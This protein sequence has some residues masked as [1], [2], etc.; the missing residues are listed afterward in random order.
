MKNIPQ[1]SPRLGK[2]AELVPRCKTVADIGTDHAY[3]PVY[4]VTNGVAERAVAS[5]IRKGPVARARES[6]ARYELSDKIDVR[7]GAGLETIGAGEAEVVVV[8]GMGGILIS[9]ILDKSRDRIVD[10]KLLILQ[11]M[12]AEAELREYLC[13]NGYGICGE[14]LVCEEDKL[15]NIITAV[16]RG[17]SEYTEVEIYMGRGLE[18]N[19]PELAAE[20]RRRRIEKLKK[21]IAGLERAVNKDTEELAILRRLLEKIEGE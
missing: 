20:Y 19:A 14:Y 12:T 17:G 10:A 11:P 4:L 1:L 9:D 6:A 2:I 21:R 8:A 18:E 7:L 16:S 13:K 15:Y 5:D 3:I